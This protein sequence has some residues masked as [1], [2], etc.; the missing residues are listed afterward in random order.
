MGLSHFA[1]SR[2]SQLGERLVGVTEDEIV[3]IDMIDVAVVVVAMTANH[4]EIAHGMVLLCAPNT[5]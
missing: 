3:T 5:V 4:P 1:G 2:L